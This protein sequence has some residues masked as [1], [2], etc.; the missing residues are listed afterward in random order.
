MWS[1]ADRGVY[2]IDWRRADCNEVEI[3]FGEMQN[4][5]EGT[6]SV[7][8]DAVWGGYKRKSCV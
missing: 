1:V 8:S 6:G 7:D 4:I 3:P 5:C 2:Q